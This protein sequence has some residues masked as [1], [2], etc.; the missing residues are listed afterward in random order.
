MVPRVVLSTEVVLR[1]V[2]EEVPSEVLAAE[3]VP[4]VLVS[5]EV[6]AKCSNFCK[7]GSLSQ[8]GFN[9]RC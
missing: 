6:V 5:T 7:M 1:G 9:S 8:C 4:R 3:V 2:L